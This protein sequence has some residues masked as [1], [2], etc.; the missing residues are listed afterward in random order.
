L[1]LEM[2]LFVL[3]LSSHYQGRNVWG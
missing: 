3:G 1:G 2:W